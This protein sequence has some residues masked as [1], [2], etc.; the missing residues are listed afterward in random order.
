MTPH[1]SKLRPCTSG[2]TLCSI[3]LI[4]IAPL[5]GGTYLL[6]EIA[7]LAPD[8]QLS[9]QASARLRCKPAH[10]S[11]AVPSTPEGAPQQ[12]EVEELQQARLAAGADPWTVGQVRWAAQGRQ[13]LAGHKRREALR[14]PPH[15]S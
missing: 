5:Q 7:E 2:P 14:V 12:G 8:G 11:S 15:Q 3:L 13:T 4:P 1:P 6:R 9:F 10:I